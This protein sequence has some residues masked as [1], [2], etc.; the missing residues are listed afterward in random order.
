M[1]VRNEMAVRNEMVVRE[2][3]RRPV[4]RLGFRDGVSARSS[5]VRP[6]GRSMLGNAVAWGDGWRSAKWLSARQLARG[7]EHGR[8]TSG[9]FK[10]LGL[11]GGEGVGVELPLALDFLRGGGFG[12]FK[13]GDGF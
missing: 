10:C 11:C 5:R 3:K 1:V 13:L 12:N 7:G 6:G 4:P 9:G 2:R 8:V